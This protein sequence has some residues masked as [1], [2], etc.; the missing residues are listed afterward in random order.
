MKNSLSREDVAQNE[1][2]AQFKHTLYYD[3]VSFSLQ[4]YDSHALTTTSCTV[5]LPPMEQ[6]RLVYRVTIN[7]LH[8]SQMTMQMTIRM[9]KTLSQYPQWMHAV[10]RHPSP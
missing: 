4:S 5:S 7:T 3:K 9:M 8:W 2:N 10:Q 1:R 6:R